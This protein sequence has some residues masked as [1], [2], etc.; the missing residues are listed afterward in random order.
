M[1]E[2]QHME[3]KRQWKDDLLK[4]ISAFANAEGGLLLVGY[5][6]QGQAVGIQHAQKLLEDIGMRCH[7]H[8][9]FPVSWIKAP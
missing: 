6:D 1:Q 8:T 3:F 7:C 9:L 4:W 5:D 2:S